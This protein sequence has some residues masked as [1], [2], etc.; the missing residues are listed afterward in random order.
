MRQLRRLATAGAAALGLTLAVVVP[1]GA[2]AATVIPTVATGSASGITAHTA[3][4][5]A[6]VNPNGVSTTYAFQY[7]TTTNYGSQTSTRSVGSG[8][9]AMPVQVTIANLTAGTTYHFRVVATNPL[10]TAWGTDTSFVTA[11]VP[12]S[13][14]LGAPSY[15]NES[16]VTLTGTVNPNGKA[17]TY[18]FE[19]GTTSTFGLQSAPV[20]VGSG[21][22]TK[23]VSATLSGLASGTTYYYRLLAIS[24]DGTSVTPGS[25]VVTTGTVVPPTGPAPV[26]S[27]SS[28]VKITSSSVQLNGAINPQGDPTTWYFEYGLTSNYGLRTAPGTMAGLGIRPINAPITGLRPATTYYFR[29]V[30][31]SANGLYVAPGQTFTTKVAPARYARGFTLT[32]TQHRERHGVHVTV[33]GRLVLPAGIGAEAFNGPVTIRI[34]R[35]DSY[36][37]TFM[38]V[39][40]QIRA[41][42]SYRAT[43]WFDSWHLHGQAKF[44][45]TARFGGNS[46]VQASTA[47][48]TVR[49]QAPSA[50]R[51][52]GGLVR[53][54]INSRVCRTMLSSQLTRQGEGVR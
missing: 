37:P 2:H 36:G 52:A 45:V 8:V 40:T 44:G 42:G 38:S 13:V 34:Q 41:D 32:T 20:S 47:R 26:V 22:T 16:T 30:A 43:T 49:L 9:G 31:N 33:S 50:A 29:L 35:G 14:L 12:P 5:N 54:A 24:A 11:P 39:R 1:A 27:Q 46:P 48:L 15:V 23:T 17:T 10:G 51:S 19:Y 28:A 4:L 18:T 21:T 3:I 6:S 7:G 25:I 53:S